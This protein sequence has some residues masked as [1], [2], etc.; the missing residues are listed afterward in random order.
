ME[1]LQCAFFHWLL[2]FPLFLE[3]IEGVWRYESLSE[4]LSVIVNLR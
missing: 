2:L 1:D 4:T 3:A